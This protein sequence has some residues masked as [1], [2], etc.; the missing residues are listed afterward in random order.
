MYLMYV[1]E[2]G[3]PGNNTDQSRYFCL[4]GIVVHESEW[5]LF[6]DSLLEFRRTIRDV[7]DFPLR[8][9]I[10]AVEMLRKSQFGIEKY[11]RL[12]ILRN[13]LDELAKYN[14]IS[15]TN[16]VVDKEG[17]P[18]DFDIFGAAWRTLFQRFENTLVH[19]NFPGGYKRSFGT[20]FTDATS[21]KRLSNIMRRMSAYNPIPNRYG[22]GFRDVPIQRIIEDPS[23]RNSVN[24]LPIQACDVAAYFLQQRQRPNSYVRKKRAHA[25]F[26]RLDPVLNKVASTADPQGVVRI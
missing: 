24:S 26:D 13:F 2:S 22:A 15:I 16:V 4:S 3:D 6:I 18:D 25:Y 21:G 11:D 7:Y 1:D 23:E 19:G 12:A 10:H 20:V 14:F 17:K 5:R 8:A 9:E